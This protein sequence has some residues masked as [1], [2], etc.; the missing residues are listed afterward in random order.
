MVMVNTFRCEAT[1]VNLFFHATVLL[2]LLH[3]NVE[4]HVYVYIVLCSI[5]HEAIHSFSVAVK[6]K[7]ISMQR[8]KVS[9]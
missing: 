4:L 5:W 8:E 3:V 9:R 1:S 2:L 6:Q 7:R